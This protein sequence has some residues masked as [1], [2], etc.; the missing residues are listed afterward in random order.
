[1]TSLNIGIILI[2]FICS[3]S[4]SIANT[5]E[6]LKLF[7]NH[8][9]LSAFLQKKFP[10]LKAKYF[11]ISN[12]QL[13]IVIHESNSN[14]QLRCGSFSKVILSMAVLNKYKD[15]TNIKHR[16]LYKYNKEK[17]KLIEDFL[18]LFG[19]NMYKHSTDIALCS[20]GA[21]LNLYEI[22]NIFSYSYEY[23]KD[24][25]NLLKELSNNLHCIFFYSEKNGA[26]CAFRY[27]ND[28]GCEFDC[29]IFKSKNKK[30]L[31]ADI[32]LICS[33]LN[34]FV[35][36]NIPKEYSLESNIEV[37]YGKNNELQTKL[38]YNNNI[39][40]IKGKQEKVMRTIKYI[41]R[42]RAPVHELDTIG[43]VFYKTS[44]FEKPIK[45]TLKA[46]QIINKGNIFNNLLD[47]IWYIIYNSPRKRNNSKK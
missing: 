37:F 8:L 47:S 43:W 17:I 46:K 14:I 12:K 11:I 44:L 31:Y 30:E 21:S 1:M 19:R 13:G 4:S 38:D 36:K 40:M 9:P 26:G 35:I 18:L 27:L 16:D 24:N 7:T 2:L 20:E 42:I 10:I 39:L 6:P 45:Y 28:N 34:I 33:W 29:I 32:G 3:I 41:T 23:I 15:I 5:T 25:T 22:C